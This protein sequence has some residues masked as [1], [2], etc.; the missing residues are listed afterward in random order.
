HHYKTEFLSSLSRSLSP[1]P[2][3]THTKARSPLARV[4]SFLN[5]RRACFELVA[6]DRESKAQRGRL[7]TTHGI[8]ET[9]AFMPIG[10][11]SS[12]KAVS[13]CELRE[14]DAQIILRNTYHLE[15]AYSH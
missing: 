3:R 1:T 7:I 15:R 5:L 10:T 11:Q 12:V 6:Q 4:V 2:R 13:Q 9:P 14:L 8:V